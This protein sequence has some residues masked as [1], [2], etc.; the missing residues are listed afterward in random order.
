MSG[1]LNKSIIKTSSPVEILIF[2]HSQ[3]VHFCEQNVDQRIKD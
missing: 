2:Q 1:F 3:Y